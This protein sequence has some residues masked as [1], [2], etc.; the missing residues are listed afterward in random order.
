MD[1]YYLMAIPIDEEI[2]K[3][4]IWVLY[5]VGLYFTLFWLSI[6]IYDPDENSRIKRKR[7]PTVSIILP[8]YNEEDSIEKTLESVFNLDYPK[9]K[10]RVICVNDGSTDNT[11]KILKKLKK[12]YNF[13][14]INQKNQGKYAALNTALKRIDSEFFACFDADSFTEPNSLKDMLEEF[15][16]KEVASVMP[17]MKVYNPENT[18]QR[19]QWLEY[20]INIFYKYIMGKIDCIHVTP[21]PFSLYRTEY[22]KKLGGFRKAHLTEDLE[23]ALRLQNNHYKLKQ[24]LSAV[25]YTK[26]PKHLKAFISQRTRWYQGTFFNIKDYKHFIF[27][28]NYGDFGMFHIPLVGV[29]GFLALLGVM[30]AIYLFLKE[31]Y[32]LLKRMYLTHFD[33]ITYIENWHFNTTLL[34]LNWQTLF[35][36]SILLLLLF[37]II[38]LSFIGTKERMNFFKSIK[39]FLMFLYYF[40][41]YRFI[42]AYIWLKVS[43]RIIF[44]KKNKWDKVN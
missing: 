18:L 28:R 40:V 3:I 1:L 34:D 44:R 20:I 23:M 29:T 30:T 32:Y 7:W 26:S 2:A 38:Y 43:Y 24:S 15:D 35:E 33:F 4:I 31:T 14:L 13:E 36:S 12:K 25:V 39:Y 8:M 42:I 9:N 6:L 10:L 21:G 37:I 17:I 41:I 16:S 5:F 22:V 11:L 27:N 19:V